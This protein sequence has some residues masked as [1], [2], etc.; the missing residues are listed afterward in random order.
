MQTLPRMA[1]RGSARS[2]S[3]QPYRMSPHR[4]GLLDA[5]FLDVA[6]ELPA[7]WTT[8]LTHPWAG[9]PHATHQLTELAEWP[10]KATST[11]SYS[12]FSVMFCRACGCW[13][14][15]SY[16]K[17]FIEPCIGRWRAGAENL[18]LPK[19]SRTALKRLKDGNYPYSTKYG[20][21]EFY[22]RD[23]RRAPVVNSVLVGGVSYLFEDSPTP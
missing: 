13:M 21:E 6:D 22:R 5:S 17:K 11:M 16:P 9:V 3:P 14:R 20:N 10:S 19:S 8:K 7:H 18:D 12:G 1:G 23:G 2:R 4:G 15:E